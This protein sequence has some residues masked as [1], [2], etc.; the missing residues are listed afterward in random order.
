[1][2]SRRR[3]GEFQLPDCVNAEFY[4]E[5]QID[6]NVRIN[7]VCDAMGDAWER[8]YFAAVLPDVRRMPHA[9]DEEARQCARDSFFSS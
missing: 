8:S 3:A 1:M 7:I 4:S 2:M 9:T 5:A 6:Q